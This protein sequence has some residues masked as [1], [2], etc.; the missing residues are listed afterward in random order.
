[1]NQNLGSIAD[2]L[3]WEMQ[4]SSV[5]FPNPMMHEDHLVSEGED[6]IIVKALWPYGQQD[7]SKMLSLMLLMAACFVIRMNKKRM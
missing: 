5:Y 2:L 3:W 6:N 7:V 1:M 4:Q